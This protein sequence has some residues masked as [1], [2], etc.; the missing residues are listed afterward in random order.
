MSDEVEKAQKAG[1]AEDTIFGV[2]EVI[3]YLLDLSIF[4][5]YLFNRQN[6]SQGNSLQFHL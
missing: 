5:F 3:S 1:E 6:S 2:Y 4:T